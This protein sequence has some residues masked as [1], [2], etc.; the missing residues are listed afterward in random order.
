MVGNIAQANQTQTDTL[1]IAQGDSIVSLS[2]RFIIP[3]SLRFLNC[4]PP[5]ALKIDAVNG[6]LRGKWNLSDTQQV[7]I[8]Y[9]YLNL[10]LPLTAYLHQ[11]PEV[12]HRYP[13]PSGS[14]PV[15]RR[16]ETIPSSANYDFLKS[17]T[18][19][20]GVT[21]GS[22]SNLTLHSGLNLELDGKLSD[23][24]T[25]QGVLSDQNLP[26]QPEGNTQT[27]E[28][29]D[30]V[31]IRVN[32]PNEQVV[33]GDYELS[34][35]GQQLGVYNRKLEG[36]YL[37]SHRG[38]MRNEAAGAL[39]RGQYHSNFF[40]G[41]EGNQGP[42]Q[43]VG[44]NG[45]TAIIVLAGTERVWIN[46]QPKQR[47]ENYDYVIDYS[48]AELTFTPR[49]L[50]T[51]ASRI[52]VDFQYSDLV[53]QKNIFALRNTQSWSDSKVN[54][55]AGYIQE[56]DDYHNP[57]EIEISTR[58]RA[59]LKTIGD[60]VARAY[61][62][63]IY[64][65]SAGAY[66]LQDSILIFVGAGRGTHTATFY[67][68]GK[69]GR[70]KKVYAGDLTYFTYVNVSDPNTAASEI[71]QAQYLPVKPLTLP[72]QKQYL[73]CSGGYRPTPNLQLKA[74]IARSSLDRNRFS[75]LDDGDN[76]G[77]AYLM[78]TDWQIPLSTNTQIL[79]N[80]KWQGEGRTF[81]P[82]DRWQNVE[83]HRLWNLPADSITG[84]QTFQGSAAF[85]WQELVKINY[86]F[87]R[88]RQTDRDA[89]RH[90]WAVTGKTHFVDSY[91]YNRETIQ[92]R[93]RTKAPV[94]WLRESGKLQ[95]RIY[96][97][98]PSYHFQREEQTGNEPQ[99]ADFRYNEQRLILQKSPGTAWHWQ[100]GGEWRRDD[101]HDST[102]WG[103]ASV[104]RNLFINSQLNRRTAFSGQCDFVYRQL[105][106]YELRPV[107]KNT[108]H[109]LNLLLKYEPIQTAYGGEMVWKI[110]SER[111][112]K[113]ER[114][115]FYVG[116]GLGEYLYDST[117][118]DYVSHPYGD[119]ILRILP[120]NIKEPVTS[121]TNGFRWQY[122]GSGRA[123]PDLWSR[124]STITD[125]RF[126]QKLSGKSAGFPL[127]AFSPDRVDT[128]SLYYNRQ[129]LQELTYRTLKRRAEYRLRYRRNDQ[130]SR[131]EVT[132]LE[133]NYT[134]ELA[135]FYR[136]NFM[137]KSNLESEL[138]YRHYK[139]QSEFSALRDRNIYSYRQKNTVIWNFDRKNYL[140]TELMMLYDQQH[141]KEK[142]SS[143]FQGVKI[144]WEHK[145][146]Q[147]GRWQ[148]FG[149]L[150][151]VKVRPH[152]QAI[153]YEMGNGKK[154]GLTI[155]WGIATEYRL[156][157]NLTLRA[158]YEGWREPL[159][160]VYHL[161]SGEIRAYF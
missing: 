131:L 153:P 102:G 118:A 133:S 37:D 28:E 40:T 35:Q 151:H 138:T 51:S 141:I 148:V 160:P 60:A 117:F 44:K 86:A 124:I 61:V 108:F 29:I 98:L 34:F 145:L 105:S 77:L 23:E 130:V 45:E 121:L 103:R 43:L 89:A 48:T 122:N 116:K 101:K 79:L 20:R 140:T 111:A 106:D 152:G 104:G 87:G 155:G 30:K 146:P 134:Q 93:K 123:K 13:Q 125:I 157:N 25:I 132:G 10:N 32:L 26:I 127:A 144:T 128:L 5:V 53:Y 67:N 88:L 100:V 11:P 39:T 158:S 78:E 59:Y 14:S 47:G 71:E 69:Q 12:Y 90:A 3:E 27:L 80:G 57:I 76:S 91:E 135:G 159:Y 22:T 24:I 50:I 97:Y 113:K 95:L 154:A 46:G 1:T 84:G 147:K 2:K 7:I 36:L 18:I 54:I 72:Q 73:F 33:F 41:E 129:L 139:R 96:H 156:G 15:I 82:I 65:D 99:A 92:S 150:D 161:G 149:E 142:V 8:A 119:Y 85:H 38:N 70:Y 4:S 55:A 107:S 19:F 75:P 9:E 143:L 110:E 42:Y 62:S 83:Y 66:I 68:V 136:G 16:E 17:G 94:D 52:T 21:I 31:F 126:E 120:T 6:I 114:R 49:C 74:E 58:D 112:V 81:T 63:T 56:S 109:L 115:Y 137:M 64:E